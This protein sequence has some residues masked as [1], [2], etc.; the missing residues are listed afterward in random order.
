[1]QKAAEMAVALYRL[2]GTAASRGGL[3]GRAPA[4]AIT[5]FLAPR[6]GDHTA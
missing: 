6:T 1:V 2:T 3:Y 5:D 4:G